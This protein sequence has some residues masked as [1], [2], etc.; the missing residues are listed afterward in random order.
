[1][2]NES[3]TKGREIAKNFEE[4]Y[5]SSTCRDNLA[6]QIDAALAEAVSH[7]TR[8]CEAIAERHTRCPETDTAETAGL[9]AAEILALDKPAIRAVC[10]ACEQA[11]SDRRKR[12]AE[13]LRW[14]IRR[15]FRKGAKGRFRVSIGLLRKVA[16]I[17]ARQVERGEIE[18]KHE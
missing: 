8:E 4:I 5:V 2:A 9:I 16:D 11:E 13:V 18:V 15:V 6:R 10:A 7:R 12:D 14:W 3:M 1:M 17:D